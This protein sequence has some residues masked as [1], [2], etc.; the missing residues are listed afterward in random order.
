MVN[1]FLSPAITPDHAVDGPIPDVVHICEHSDNG[2]FI[3]RA[4]P[5]ARIF[6]HLESIHDSRVH[7]R[8][9]LRKDDGRLSKSSVQEADIAAQFYKQH[10]QCAFLLC[11]GPIRDEFL[12]GWAVLVIV[13]DE[14]GWY[15]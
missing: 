2:R 4:V 12:K 10:P 15:A 1:D 6:A 13:H 3:P 11:M 9:K 5:P 7:P 8:L 14:P